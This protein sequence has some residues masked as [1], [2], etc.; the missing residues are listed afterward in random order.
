MGSMENGHPHFRRFLTKEER[1][2]IMEEY[3]EELKKELKAVE[4]QI[5]EL[6]SK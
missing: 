6:R 1:I 4:E 5:D 3:V 2:K